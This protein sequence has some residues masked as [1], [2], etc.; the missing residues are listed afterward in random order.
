MRLGNRV[1]ERLRAGL[2]DSNAG[3]PKPA[4]VGTRRKFGPDKKPAEQ[5]VWFEIGRKV[6]ALRAKRKALI[7][8]R[9]EVAGKYEYNT[10]VRYHRKYRNQPLRTSSHPG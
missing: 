4:F 5:T 2:K 7:D 9:R 1:F 10:V 6:E 8:A 3:F